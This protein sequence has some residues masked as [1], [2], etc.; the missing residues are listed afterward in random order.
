MTVNGRPVE[1]F[2]DPGSSLLE[3]LRDHL[4]LTGTKEGCRSGDCGA[5]TV[6]V[7][8][9]AVC[10]CIYLAI[11]ADGRQVLTVEGLALGD[12]LHPLQKA[13]IKNGVTQCGF[14][15][16]G[17][18]MSANALLNENPDLSDD[19]IREALAGNL[20]RCS[21]YERIVK[22]VREAAAEVARK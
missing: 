13:F 16:P 2:C 18:L 19:K 8:G 15:T 5:C 4:Q 6:N 22:S 20:C 12:E 1:I 17:M 7:D 3:V 11:Q 14:C 10:S 21:S 9:K